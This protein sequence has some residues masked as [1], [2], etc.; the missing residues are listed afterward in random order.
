[1]RR[2]F[3]WLE[4]VFF[5]LSHPYTFHAD[6]RRLVKDRDRF[7]PENARDHEH[8]PDEE[9]D[10]RNDQMLFIHFLLSHGAFA[11]PVFM[12]F[13]CEKFL[14]LLRKQIVYDFLPLFL[15]SSSEVHLSDDFSVFVH[16]NCCRNS[17]DVAQKT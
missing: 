4:S 10:D 14:L 7:I 16:E 3:L 5:I 15:A 8:D 6:A 9:K 17:L 13:I 1:M 2:I 11:L 12:R